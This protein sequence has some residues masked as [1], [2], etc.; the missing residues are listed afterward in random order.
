MYHASHLFNLRRIVDY[1]SVTS[2]IK[3]EFNSFHLHGNMTAH[4]DF[5]GQNGYGLDTLFI[6]KRTSIEKIQ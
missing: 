3:G 2:V 1:P 6:Y 4:Y 5:D